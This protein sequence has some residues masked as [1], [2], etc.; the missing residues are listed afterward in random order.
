[1]QNIAEN[2]ENMINDY[3]FYEQVNELIFDN[4]I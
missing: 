2:K 4:D 3:M 1:M